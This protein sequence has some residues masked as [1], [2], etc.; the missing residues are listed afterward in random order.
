[1]VEV[2]K[3]FVTNLTNQNSILVEIKSRWNSWEASYHSVQNLV[4]SSLLSKN[5]KTEIYRTII[6]PTLLYGCENVS[7][8][9]RGD[10]R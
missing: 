2:F 4:S 8:V 3:Y 5:I 10:L 9:L 6:L 7:F 1:M